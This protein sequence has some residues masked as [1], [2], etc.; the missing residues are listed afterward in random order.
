M[1]GFRTHHEDHCKKACAT[2]RN[3]KCWNYI[4][5]SHGKIFGFCHIVTNRKTIQ[6]IYFDHNMKIISACR[7][8]SPRRWK[9]LSLRSYQQMCLTFIY[10][11]LFFESCIFHSFFIL[12]FIFQ[13]VQN[14]ACGYLKKSLNFIKYLSCNFKVRIF[15]LCLKGICLNKHSIIFCWKLENFRMEDLLNLFLI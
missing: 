15:W 9:T 5:R 1:R 14:S 12:L 13:I 11:I 6:K 10:S 4:H 8:A 7:N 3:C 2:I